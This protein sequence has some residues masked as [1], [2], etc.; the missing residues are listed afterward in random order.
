MKSQQTVEKIEAPEGFSIE[1]LRI[2]ESGTVDA[3]LHFRDRPCGAIWTLGEAD[4]DGAIAWADNIEARSAWDAHLAAL[5]IAAAILPEGGTLRFKPGQG[6][7]L[8]AMIEDASDRDFC[9]GRLVYRLKSDEDGQPWRIVAM[10]Y[11]GMAKCWLI[12][13]HGDELGEVMNERYEGV[14]DLAARP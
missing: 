6:D 4:G 11:C 12:N 9:A 8:W 1:H 7:V 13:R 5:P 10:R 3:I 14:V 2:D